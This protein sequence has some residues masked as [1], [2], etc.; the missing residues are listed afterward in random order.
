MRIVPLA[1]VCLAV[2]ATDVA[3][4]DGFRV[5]VRSPTTNPRYAAYQQ[6]IE[7][8]RMLHLTAEGM[9]GAFRIPSPAWITAEECGEVNAFWRPDERAI[10]ICYE[11]IDEIFGEFRYDGL[12]DEEFGTAVESTTMFILMHEVG[13]ALVD[14]LNLPV[15]GREED[16]VD[17]FA[18]ILLGEEDVGPAWWA[19]EYWRTRGDFGDTGLLKVDDTPYEDEHSFDLQRFYNVLCWAYGRDPAGRTDV[20]SVLPQNRAVRC[21]GEYQRMAAAWETILEPHGRTSAAPPSRPVRPATATFG[22]EWRLVEQIG[23]LNSDFYCENEIWLNVRQDG[24][25]FEAPYRQSGRC[26]V[27]GQQIDNPGVGQVFGALHGS[28]VSFTMETC[29][30]V[31][32]LARDGALRGTLSCTVMDEDGASF[33]IDGV[34]RGTRR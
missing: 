3:A 23:A 21:P 33:T 28:Q 2:A 8:S 29:S 17:Q 15:T 30:Y 19:A 12:S 11:M 26:T 34:W 9:N 7:Q 22:G 32:E 4:Q 27:D 16:V 18:T 1:L 31:G 25:T 20:L 24:G 14:L 6:W 10:T 13:H 5:V